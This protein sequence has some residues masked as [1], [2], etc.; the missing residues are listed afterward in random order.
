MLVLSCMSVIFPLH[1]SKHLALSALHNEPT[2]LCCN[3]VGMTLQAVEWGFHTVTSAHSKPNALKSYM[4]N[5]QC[6]QTQVRG[7]E[8]TPTED[9][10]PQAAVGS[11]GAPGRS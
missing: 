9:W 8:R 4:R 11:T 10:V 3:H 1:A 7:G 6:T 2:L 5:T